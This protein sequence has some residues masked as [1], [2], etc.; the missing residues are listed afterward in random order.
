MYN[1]EKKIKYL[2]EMQKGTIPLEF[3]N[4]GEGK[5]Y[6]TPY[7]KYRAIYD[8]LNA[9]EK[10]ERDC[11]EIELNSGKKAWKDLKNY[12]GIVPVYL[13]AAAFMISGLGIFLDKLLEGVEKTI[14]LEN[15]EMMVWAVCV[16]SAIALAAYYFLDCFPG[17]KYRKKEY[18]LDVLKKVNEEKISKKKER[19]VIETSGDTRTYIV[20]IREKQE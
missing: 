8:L 17:K 12:V 18:I 1:V 6:K 13:T 3:R 11:I 14:V 19:E 20:T 10:D 2:I 9:C 15:M 7:E 4:D 16:I 5:K